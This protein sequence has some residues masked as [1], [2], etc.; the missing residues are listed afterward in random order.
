MINNALSCLEDSTSAIPDR[1][2]AIRELAD[3]VYDCTESVGCLADCDETKRIENTVV[4]L[5]NCENSGSLPQATLIWILGKI[6][7]PALV[8]YYKRWLLKYVQQ[9]NESSAAIHNTLINLDLIHGLQ[10]S[11]SIAEMEENLKRAQVYLADE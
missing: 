8:P 2:E 1:L 5:L 6:D 9:L 3:Y 10:R 7:N 4:T 11:A